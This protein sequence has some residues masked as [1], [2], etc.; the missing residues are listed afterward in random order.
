MSATSSHTISGQS[1]CLCGSVKITATKINPNFSACHCDTCRKWGGAPYFSLRCGVDVKIEGAENITRYESSAWAFRGFCSSCG[2][3]LFYQIKE[4]GE[5]NMPVGL[6]L[7]L[8]GLKMEMQYYSDQR[9]DYY[10]FSNE[11]REMTKA[12]VERYFS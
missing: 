5:Y 3:H 11:T 6:F 7:N 10:C 8:E 4:T 9:P 12:E 2:T 1:A